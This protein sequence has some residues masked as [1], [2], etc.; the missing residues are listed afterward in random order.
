MLMTQE[1]TR[2]SRVAMQFFT[3]QSSP[4]TRLSRSVP[5]IVPF[6]SSYVHNER[7]FLS[8]NIF[9][10]VTTLRATA[11]ALFVALSFAPS[12]AQQA[13]SPSDTRP[14]KQAE[15][16]TSQAKKPAQGTAAKA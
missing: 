4:A 1:R 3:N 2:N 14:S 9:S 13:E 8:N 10:E 16:P 7:R 5:V 15:Q 12:L 6:R 11:A